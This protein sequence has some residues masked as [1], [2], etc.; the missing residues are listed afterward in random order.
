[1]SHPEESGS[2]VAPTGKASV[3]RSVLSS[4]EF[5]ASEVRALFREPGVTRQLAEVLQ[6]W[7]FG[8]FRLNQIMKTRLH[9]TISALMAVC[10]L[11]CS[12]DRPSSALPA[13]RGAL[14]APPATDPEIVKRPPANVDPQAVERPPRNADPEMA[15]AP[16]TE[17]AARPE[18]GSPTPEKRSREDDCIGPAYRCKQGSER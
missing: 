4:D 8:C 6:Q 18:D 16:P 3:V 11:A 13:V 1:M 10:T 15:K 12:Q 9:A 2:C 14:R 7:P 17:R 5:A